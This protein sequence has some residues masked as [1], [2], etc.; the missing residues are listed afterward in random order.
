MVAGCAYLAKD[1][2]HRF[3]SI[4]S[5]SHVNISLYLPTQLSSVLLYPFRK[6]MTRREVRAG[7]KHGRIKLDFPIHVAKLHGSLYI[8][9]DIKGEC[10]K[11]PS[12]V[13]VSQF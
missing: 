6:N 7:V 5:L 13:P 2:C 11:A 9:Y 1:V 10:P 4:P 8:W 12:P 3:V